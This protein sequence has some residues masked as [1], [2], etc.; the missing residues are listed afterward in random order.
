MKKDFLKW[1][2]KKSIINDISQ[3]PFFHEREIWFCHLGVNVGFE[4][5]G[6][7]D[8]FMRPIL[9]FRKFS[10]DILW[11]FPLTKTKKEKSYYFRFSFKPRIE[12]VAILSQIRLIDARR[13]SYKMGEIADHDFLLLNQK[14]KALLP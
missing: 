8:D 14:F 7:G 13:L 3:P 9:I 1:S 4:E 12:S 6:K 5:D 2:A 11:G 10:R